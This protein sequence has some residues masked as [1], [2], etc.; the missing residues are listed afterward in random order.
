MQKRTAEELAAHQ[1]AYSTFEVKAINE[2]KREIEGWATTP[3]PDLMGDIVEPD[4]ADF[5]LPVPLL[6]Q[7]NS[8]QPIG[9]VI[10]AKVT[11]QGI[12]V[13]VRLAKLA[14][15]APQV[16]KDRIDEAW[17]SV[18]SGLVKAFSIGFRSKEHSEIEGSWAYRFI[19]WEWLE[20]SL[21]TIPA[22]AEATITA[23]KSA[24]Q[25]VRAALGAKHT[26]VVRL[27]K[28]T[29]G[30]S[31]QRAA[32][33]KGNSEMKTYKEQ[34][35]ALEATRAAKAARM[36]E[37]Q[38]AATEASRT[39]DAA[40][41]EEFE[42][43]GEEIEGIDG[44]L[45][46]LAALEKLNVAAA[47]TVDTTKGAPEKPA[48]GAGARVTINAKLEPG[49]KFARMA[50]CV[51]RAKYLQKEGRFM[52]PEDIYR[53]EKRWMDTAP[54]V[55]IAMKAAV[56]ANDS[57]TAAG[58]SEWAYAQNIASEFIEF[59]RPKTLLGRISGWR[60]VPFNVR[61]G[62]MDGGTTGFWVGQ[63]AA[64]NLSRP[65]STSVSLGITKVGG[66]SVITKELA[67]LSTPS[68]ELS[69]RNDLARAVQQ[70]ADTSLIDPNSGGTTNVQPASLTYGVTARQA[71]GTDFAAFKAD[72]KAMTSVFYAA[73]IPLD[74]AVVIMKEEL[75]EALA[76]M[77]TSL[78]L[79]QFPSMQDYASGNARLMGRPV[80]TSQVL[81]ASGSPDF[82]NLL[83]LLQPGEVFLADDGGASIEASDQV[84][85]QMDDAPTNKSTATATGASL[86]SMFQTDSIALKAL[87]HVNWTKARSQACQFI[88]SAAYV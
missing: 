40:E 41:R 59:L 72:W 53:A 26:V 47:E 34:I 54:E 9:E 50:M 12:K 42:T 7:H 21:V 51:A 45:K 48:A 69:V 2:E 60:Q 17:H 10:E 68:A 29:P 13:R 15:N 65:T 36:A 35:A 79:P 33:Q 8:R 56:N 81:D 67:M 63:G 71:S 62:G 43:L 14:A 23:I 84:S 57:S 77:V 19:K 52:A 25:R 27:D 28:S 18:K 78:G 32:T 39:K 30:A 37:I 80:I 83:I 61:V 74:G 76:M 31:G 3:E 64:I 86:V 11:K 1:F 58:A 73:N 22:N 20:L 4:G 38:K 82:D 87:R 70:K 75:A 66:L 46:D 16:L 24:D 6:W 85:I 5:K 49:V 88:R 44:E 55:Q